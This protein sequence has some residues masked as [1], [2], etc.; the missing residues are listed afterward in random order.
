MVEKEIRCDK[1]A[2]AQRA[3]SRRGASV[4]CMVRRALLTASAQTRMT[5]VGWTRGRRNPVLAS[6]H[7]LVQCGAPGPYS[8]SAR[9]A[10]HQPVPGRN[11]RAARPVATIPPAPLR[12][13]GQMRPQAAVGCSGARNAT[14]VRRE[15]LLLC[16]ARRRTRPAPGAAT[17]HQARNFLFSGS[18]G[19]S[20]STVAFLRWPRIS[21]S[22]SVPTS[23]WAVSM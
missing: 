14:A 8:C 1:Q 20:I 17:R 19:D 15:I 22:S 5:R 3:S 12:T 6:Y 11:P 16:V 21:I 13:Q 18:S 10:Q 9:N 7:L 2:P 4:C 23:Q